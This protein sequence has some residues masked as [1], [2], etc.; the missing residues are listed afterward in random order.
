MSSEPTLESVK[1]VVRRWQRGVL[2]QCD[3]VHDL[4]AAMDETNI[5]DAMLIVPADLVTAIREVVNQRP[6]TEAE[7]ND[8]KLRYIGGFVP[9]AHL[10]RKQLREIYKSKPPTPEELRAIRL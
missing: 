10:T 6:K 8:L 3:A 5:K 4:M 1:R 7:W 9:R 2:L